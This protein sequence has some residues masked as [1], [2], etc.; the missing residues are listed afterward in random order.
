MQV[1]LKQLTGFASA[2]ATSPFTVVAVLGVYTELGGLVLTCIVEKYVCM[3]VFHWS[4]D[5]L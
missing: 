3:Y 5:L 1:L 4:L 2:M